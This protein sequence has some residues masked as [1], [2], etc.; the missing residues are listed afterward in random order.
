MTVLGK[1]TL[2]DGS[3]FWEEHTGEVVIPDGVGALYLT[4]K[5]NGVGQLKSIRFE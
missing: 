2:P 1:I 3:N 5:G 4:F